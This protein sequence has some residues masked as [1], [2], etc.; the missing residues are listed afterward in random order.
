[1]SPESSIGGLPGERE[2]E[3]GIR[4]WL[5]E[6]ALPE[7][8]RAFRDAEIKA[9]VRGVHLGLAVAVAAN[10]L[11]MWFEW[12]T[13]GQVPLAHFFHILAAR[14]MLLTVVCG[15]LLVLRW[16]PRAFAWAVLIG[17]VALAAM[18]CVVAYEYTN[19]LHRAYS[20]VWFGLFAFLVA[21]V[22]PVP[23]RF[24]AASAL[25]FGAAVLLLNLVVV[26]PAF[27]DMPQSATLTVIAG[28]MG[29][30]LAN[31]LNRSRRLEH[32]LVASQQQLNAVLRGEVAV[33]TEAAA[34]LAERKA[35]LEVRLA[36]AE[37]LEALGRL[38][39][40][41]AHDLNNLLTPIMG[42]T[43][44]VRRRLAGREPKLAEMLGE[45]QATAESAR[46]LVRQMLAFGRRQVIDMRPLDLAKWLDDQR[47]LLLAQLGPRIEL[48]VQAAGPAVVRADPTQMGQVLMNLAVNARDA[49]SEGGTL[50]IGLQ[51]EDIAA[52]EDLVP[53]RYLVL[54]VQDTGPGMDA[55]TRERLFEPFFTTKKGQ[56]SGLGLA[57]VYGIVRQHEGVVRVS[58]QPGQ[59]TIF[60]IYLRT[61]E[62]T[63]GPHSPTPVA[64]VEVLAGR[65]ET[66]LLVDDDDEV[67]G[68]V[69]LLL[70]EAGFRVLGATSGA[71]AL[72]V[73][74][75]HQGRIHVVLTDVV[76]EG[77]SGTELWA[78]L[79][80]E[81]P[82][83]RVLF[84]SGY[85]DQ[86][87]VH[88]RRD[89]RIAF[90]QKPFTS[91]DL[92]RKLRSL[93]VEVS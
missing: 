21:M 19:T 39:G 5:A 52:A 24:G 67:R 61:T 12:R 78:A 83:T 17:A 73:A 58:S 60:S 48:R 76:M 33:R 46:D 32:A 26:E 10:L 59:G 27:R 79:R 7:R 87:L 88:D 8:E 3:L 86:T 77:M 16:R 70:T 90:L 51:R 36:Q 44:L 84:M 20:P 35:E 62:D 64:G 55:L 22:F 82:D 53:G 23:L 45:A 85:A 69:Q 30:A 1:M 41:V 63:A 56:H 38:A 50:T 31:R 80:P 92:Y 29:V 65:S 42:Y 81:R 54:S 47:N 18:Q 43:D 74:R 71:D 68:L 28:G 14:V 4:P 34:R 37:R 72:S 57:T 25:V 49:M 2:D 93:L 75:S 11:S 91:Q 40:G 13:F 15:M 66:V 6:F 89:D 9:T